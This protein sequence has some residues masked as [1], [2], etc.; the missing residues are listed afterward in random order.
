M[1]TY[2]FTGP[3][4][5]RKHTG[6][7]PVCNKRVT[8]SRTFEKTVNPFNRNKETGLIKTWEEVASEVNAEADAW[9]PDFTHSACAEVG[10]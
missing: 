8:R 6:K 7:C 10:K 3:V 4:T 5:S 2:V 1:P 9:V